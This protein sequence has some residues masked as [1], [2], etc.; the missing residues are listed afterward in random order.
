MSDKTDAGSSQPSLAI[1]VRVGGEL[2]GT[3]T[4]PQDAGY[5]LIIIAGVEENWLVHRSEAGA[6]EFL[7]KALGADRFK[8]NRGVYEITVPFGM[9]GAWVG[10]GSRVAN[11]LASCLGAMLVIGED[12]DWIV[13]RCSRIKAER[14]EQLS[15]RN[16]RQLVYHSI[17]SPESLPHEPNSQEIHDTLIELMNRETPDRVRQFMEACGWFFSAGTVSGLGV[18]IVVEQ[19]LFKQYQT[20]CFNPALPPSKH[21]DRTPAAITKA[22]NI[23]AQTMGTDELETRWTERLEQ[24]KWRK[25][26]A[27]PR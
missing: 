8:L 18:L 16:R 23:I 21:E 10:S 11:F 15:L 4:P 3:E 2:T 17:I 25:P 14:H 26:K 1:L 7:T 12:R 19:G 22:A 27:P 20:C 6:L 24:L 5:E 13:K 9:K